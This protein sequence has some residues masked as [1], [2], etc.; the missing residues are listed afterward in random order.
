MTPDV[1]TIDADEDIDKV[2]ET[3]DTERIIRVPVTS[4]GR[5]VGVIARADV[6]RAKLTP[7]FVLMG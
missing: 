3:L 7:R 4:G 1:I 2:M 5:L 6:I